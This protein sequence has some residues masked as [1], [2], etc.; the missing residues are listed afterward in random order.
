MK[1]NIESK[2]IGNRKFIIELR[3][4][5]KVTISDKKGS[6]IEN[7]RNLNIFKPLHW[8]IGVANATIWDGDSKEDARNT[9]FIELN[10]LSFISTK[11]DSVESYY[12]NFIKIY[13]CLVKEVGEFNI[14]RIGCRVQ[15]T[16]KT[17]SSDFNSIF[18]KMKN[19]FPGQFYLQD[20]P[21][22]DM[23]FQLNY[24][25]GMYVIGP[26]NE[27]KDAF[28]ESN[29]PKSYRICHNGIAIDT[30]NYL[31]NEKT[32]INDKKL[33]KD[34]YVLSLSVEKKLFDN[35]SDL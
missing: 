15:G 14:H 5:H 10:R 25:N 33:I 29:F 28:I 26:S 22:T 7:I 11:I 3:F 6:I 27:N 21:S 9:V 20:F 23:S 2:H 12:N 4:E 8:E 24:K 17:K 35:L 19:G 16:Y 13:D 30:D 32:S 1:D 31:T 34:T 18:D